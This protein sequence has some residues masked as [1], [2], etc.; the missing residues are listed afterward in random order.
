MPKVSGEEAY[1]LKKTSVAV[2]QLIRMG[3]E[4]VTGK[5]DM[6]EKRVSSQKP[7]NEAVK[8]PNLDAPVTKERK[9]VLKAS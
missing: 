3:E 5:S 6:K 8:K 9:P 4:F 1:L 7:K 2:K